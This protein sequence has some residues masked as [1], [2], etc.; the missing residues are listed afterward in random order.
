MAQ[1][2]GHDGSAD[3][4]GISERWKVAYNLHGRDSETNAK[5]LILVGE[6]SGKLDW[7]V[8]NKFLLT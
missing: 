7:A 4:V 1:D 5:H 8:G 2:L 3:E 6:G